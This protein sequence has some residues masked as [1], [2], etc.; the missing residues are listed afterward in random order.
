M[1][2][3]ARK[4]PLGDASIW[5]CDYES[6]GFDFERQKDRRSQLFSPRARR[7]AQFDFVRKRPRNAY[8]RVAGGAQIGVA[9]QKAVVNCR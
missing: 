7:D 6:S 9:L 2:R 3:A 5:S 4:R 1:Y 8:F